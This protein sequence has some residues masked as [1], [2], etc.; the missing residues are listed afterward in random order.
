MRYWLVLHPDVSRP[1]GGVKQ[2]HRLCE[3]ILRAGRE[4]T[5]IQEAADF[6]PGWFVSDVPTIS[7]D[8]WLRRRDRG[9]FDPRKDV[10]I[11]PETYLSVLS[12]YAQDLPV[13]LFNQNGS[14]SFGL[15]DSGQYWKPAAVLNRYQHASIVHVL[16]VSLS[17]RALLVNGFGLEDDR[18]S[19]I[20]NGLETQEC[21]P[22]GSKSLKMAVMPRKNPRDVAVVQALLR[23]QPWMKK[24][25]LVDIQSR[26]HAEVIKL[27]QGCALFLSFG[28]PEGFGLPVAEAMACGCAVI[29]YSGLG[30]RELFQ[31]G[32]QYGTAVEVAFGDWLGFVSAAERLDQQLNADA[33]AFALKLLAASKQVRRMYSMEKMQDSVVTALSRIEA[34]VDAFQSRAT[35]R[36]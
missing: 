2:M 23:Q 13:V 36:V 29:G 34:R 22:N 6:H 19:C 26:P 8:D 17:D 12:D 24:W 5:V 31:L 4:A 10:V 25:S 7:H 18:V 9:D 35:G 21:R 11:A 27:L 28:H 20:R 15:A 16:C 3:C 14:Y 33:Q 32:H 30:G 1:I